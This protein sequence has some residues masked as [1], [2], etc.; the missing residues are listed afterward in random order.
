M[1]RITGYTEQEAIG[2]T[3]EML[4]FNRCLDQNCP[5]DADTCGILQGRKVSPKECVLRHKDGFDIPVLKNARAIKESDGTIIG[6]VETLTDLSQLKRAEVRVE[7]A[8]RLLGERHQYGNIIGKSHRMQAVFQSM[9]RAAA[10]ARN[11]IRTKTAAIR[12]LRRMTPIRIS[13]GSMGRAG[14]LSSESAP[15]AS[16]T[17]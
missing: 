10:S 11:D 2:K 13:T 12:V 4:S 5:G 15:P 16:T 8:S 3:C 7:E 6:V 17:T 9:A 14:P 1:E